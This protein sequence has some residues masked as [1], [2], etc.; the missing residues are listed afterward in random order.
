M[1][2]VLG[3]L[4]PFA[5]VT[6]TPPPSSLPPLFSTVQIFNPLK[7]QSCP[8]R[9]PQRINLPTKRFF[10]I[11]ASATNGNNGNGGNDNKNDPLSK[12]AEGIEENGS[13][14]NNGEPVG[15][16]GG[17]GTGENRRPRLNL[18][19]VDLLLDPDPDNVVAVG[20]TGVLAWAS[21]QVLWQLFVIS[22]A[23]MLAA[24]KYSFVAALLIFILITL[25]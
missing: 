2:S 10:F 4:A 5:G 25:L 7:L 22:I 3:K 19:W 14:K 16:N 6:V 13:K 15:G 24:L 21:V 12:E 11:S 23:I 9:Y 17:G 18:K 8:S 1:R 20:L